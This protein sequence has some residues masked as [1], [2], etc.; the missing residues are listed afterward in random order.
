MCKH[1]QLGSDPDCPVM[2]AI[3]LNLIVS[4]A[5]EASGTGQLC[6]FLSPVWVSDKLPTSVLVLSTC[7]VSLPDLNR[8]L[9]D[10]NRTLVPS[11][12]REIETLGKHSPCAV[13]HLPRSL[14]LHAGP[15]DSLPG[16]LRCYMQPSFLTL[17]VPLLVVVGF[18]RRHHGGVTHDRCSSQVWARDLDLP[19]S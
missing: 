10:L 5:T 6:P 7:L 2:L 19:G 1:R 13:S 9:V 17:P 16:S 8:T 3:S 11:A 15:N 18:T 12:P 14:C 4:V